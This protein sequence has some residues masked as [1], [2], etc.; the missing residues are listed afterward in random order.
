MKNLVTYFTCLTPALIFI[1]TLPGCTNDNQLREQCTDY[2]DQ[3]QSPYVLPWPAGVAYEVLTGN[4]TSGNPT[5]S[6]TRKYAYDFKMP[7]GAVITAGRSGTVAFLDESNSDDD[8]TFGNENVLTIAHEDGTYSLYV[9]FMENGIDV[10][11]NQAVLQGDT[12]GKLGT[13][14]SIGRAMI[15]HLHFEEVLSFDPIVSAP[16][17]FSNTSPHPNGLVVGEMYQAL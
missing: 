7:F 3:A 10:E 12:L 4:C 11:I 17:T 16:L 15:P 9:H 6:G 13:S 14:G 8:H 1:L 2:P 5:H